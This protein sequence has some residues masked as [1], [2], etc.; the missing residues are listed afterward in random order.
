MSKTRKR[1]SYKR[2]TTFRLNIYLLD[3]LDKYVD[4]MN[5]KGITTTKTDVV[6]KAIYKYIKESNNEK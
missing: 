1:K 6:E 3:E 4:D 2:P 5:L